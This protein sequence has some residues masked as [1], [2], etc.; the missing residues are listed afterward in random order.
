MKIGFIGMTL[1]DTATL[2]TPAG[3]AGLTFA[4]E[5]ASANALVPMLKAQG[6][7]AIVLLIHQGGKPGE[8]YPPD[9][10]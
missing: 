7:D 10:M 2:V 5:A 6:A 3:V 4:D 9:G 1:K 8:N